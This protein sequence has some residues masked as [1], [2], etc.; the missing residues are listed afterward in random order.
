MLA[1][2]VL[3]TD[4]YASALMEICWPVVVMGMDDGAYLAGH[5]HQYIICRVRCV[6]IFSISMVLNK[7]LASLAGH[8]AIAI[9]ASCIS[10][11]ISM[12]RRMHGWVWI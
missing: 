10:I 5:L 12:D 1:W 6:R 2:R 8:H 9:L 7:L 3:F 4:R 11:S